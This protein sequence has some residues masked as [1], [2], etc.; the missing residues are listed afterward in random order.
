MPVSDFFIPLPYPVVAKFKKLQTNGKSRRLVPTCSSKFYH[1]F[2]FY[3]IGW[4][5]IR[6]KGPASLCCLWEIQ[7]SEPYCWMVFDIGGKDGFLAV[8]YSLA[9]YYLLLILL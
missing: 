9:C 1:H 3:C 2:E 7:P 5:M 8:D 4:Y 6:E